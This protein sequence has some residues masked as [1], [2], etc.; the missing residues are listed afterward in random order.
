MGGAAGGLG[1]EV[2]RHREGGKRRGE[3]GREDINRPRAMKLET[4]NNERGEGLDC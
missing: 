1:I 4:R 3:E 2:S